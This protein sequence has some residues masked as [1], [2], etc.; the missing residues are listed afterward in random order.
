MSK[1]EIGVVD[2]FGELKNEFYEKVREECGSKFV[3][4]ES[5]GVVFSMND[6]LFRNVCGGDEELE[7]EIEEMDKNDNLDCVVGMGDDVMN[8]LLV[9]D[10]NKLSEKEKEFIEEYCGGNC[11]S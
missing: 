1:N 5:D 9:K 11:Y 2:K 7:K 4:C 6:N 3:W 8:C 10:L